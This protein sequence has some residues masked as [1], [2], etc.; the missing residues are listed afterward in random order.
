M[1][2]YES[3]HNEPIH[4]IL[5]GDFMSNIADIA[6]RAGVST[7]TVSKILN[8]DSSVKEKNREKVLKAMEE[9][10]YRPNLYA[11][12]LSKGSTKLISVII[13]TIGHEFV[14]RLVNSMDEVFSKYKYDSILF[15]M[16]SRER[17]TRFEDP[18]HFLYHTDG[19]II[20]SLS[21]SSMFKGGK[22]P[23]NKPLVMVDTYDEQNDC[24][25]VDNYMG[26]LLA[27]NKLN[28]EENSKIY[29]VGGYES[30][31]TFTSKVF[32]ER[33]RGFFEGIIKRGLDKKRIIIKEM[34]L[35]WEKAFK[36]GR[37]SAL[38]EKKKFS[39]F[40]MS[41]I[42]ARGFIEGANSVDKKSG[43]D[44]FLVGY[45]NLHF[46]EYL[47]IS[48]IGQPIEEMGR[49]AA[50]NLITKIKNPEQKNITTKLNPIYFGRNSN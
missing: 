4:I 30:D 1:L 38:N 41:D 24:V 12:N 10:K 3:I 16:L 18:F 44:Y 22:L 49:L 23:A 21:I 15:P 19:M 28:I 14:S 32:Q 45:D 9:L 35:D 50:E 36:S 11:R 39:V 37:D 20:A 43:K 46:S 40:C 25:Y 29:I 26:G 8:N 5:E 47:N 31:S 33:Q 6:K 2:V 7:G 48:T 27:A 13:P 34:A 42:L 17:L